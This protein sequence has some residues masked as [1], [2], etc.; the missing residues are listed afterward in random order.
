MRVIPMRPETRSRNPRQEGQ[1]AAAELRRMLLGS[2][3]HD[4]PLPALPDLLSALLAL[5]DGAREKSI[6][7]LGTAPAELVLVRRGARVFVSYLVVDGVTEPRALDRPIALDTLLTRCAA[8][9]EAAAMADSDPTSRAITLKLA[10]RAKGAVLCAVSSEPEPVEK[11]GGAVAAPVARIPLAF[12]FQAEIVPLSDPPRQAGEHSDAHALLFRGSLW[13]WARGRRVSIVRGP[14]MIAVQRMVAAVRALIEAWETSRPLNVRLRAGTFTVGARLERRG[15]ASLTIGSDE[16]GPI[17]LPELR[18]DEAALPILRL[19]SEIL[20]ALVSVDRAQSRNLRVSSLRDEVRALRRRV[21]AL[22]PRVESIV[23]EDPD[24][25]R[26]AAACEPRE[27]PE[28]AG[29]PRALRFERR[30]QAEV[31]GLDAASTFL[32]GDRI[33]VAT[34]RHVAA[35]ARDDG[36]MLWSRREA[37]SASFM[38]GTVLVRVASDGRVSLHDPID[39]EP[40]ASARIAPRTQGAQCGL[41]AGGGPIPPVAVLAEGQS[42]LVAID[43]RTAELRWRFGASR[44]G[45]F[46]LARS[47]RILLVVRGDGSVSALDVASGELLWRFAID[48]RFT[49]APVIAGDLVAVVSGSGEHAELHAIDLYSGRLAWQRALDRA[50]SGAPIGVG[51]AILVATAGARSAQLVAYGTSDGEPR[52]IVPDP[53]A[54][55]GGAAIAIDRTLVVNGPL[56]HAVALDLDDGSTRWKRRLA[57]PVADDVPRRLEPVLRGGALFVPS[58]QVHVL[59]PSDGAPIAESLGL[60]ELVPDWMRVDERGWIYVAEESGHLAALAPRPQLALVR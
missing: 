56:G 21:R 12:G 59:R 51:D 15:S 30:W 58:A 24:R 9:A 54:A 31:E 38:T 43:L 11:S 53:G 8:I 57:H 25:L 34:P 50:P 46:A 28:P 7:P 55:L 16:E 10:E 39:G 5:A 4:L 49:S 22:G 52:W 40:F 36:R 23:H 20:R 2:V 35:I 45:S 37:A 41:L 1:A 48:G 18:V 6:L 14:V 29:P 26:A 32:C 19:A 47:G 13:M 27:E 33:V 3:S 44:P 17:T 42:R 60:S